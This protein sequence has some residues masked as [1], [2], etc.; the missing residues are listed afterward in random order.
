MKKGSEEFY[1]DEERIKIVRG[2]VSKCGALDKT[3]EID[4]YHGK[5]AIELI[6]S[7]SIDDRVKDFFTGFIS[8]VSES[9]E[10]YK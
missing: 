10:W 9:L 2:I 8:F 3:K 1:S 7:T 6:R 4:R 5:K